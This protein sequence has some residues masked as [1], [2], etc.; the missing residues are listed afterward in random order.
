MPIETENLRYILGLKLKGLRQGRGYSLT[1]AA[2]RAG[3]SISY[4]SEIEKGRKYPK[5]DKLLK[6][7]DAFGVPYDELVSLQ[8]EDELDPLKALLSS[9]FVREFPFELFGVEPESLFDLMTDA[10]AKAGALIRTLLEIAQTYDVQ[11]EH[12]LFAALR[13]YQLMHRNHFEQLEAA[14]TAYR[15]TR[16]RLAGGCAAGRGTPAR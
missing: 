10:P 5:P 2:E 12:F 16:T 11:V 4:L 15:E 7:A 6:L 9:N 3:V 8:L 13:A 14:A 1:E